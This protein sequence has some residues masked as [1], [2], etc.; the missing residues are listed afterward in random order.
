MPK[1]QTKQQD[2]SLDSLLLCTCVALRSL[3]PVHPTYDI[4]PLQILTAT[5]CQLPRLFTDKQILFHA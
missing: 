3:K 2:L 5:D 1:Q 4:N